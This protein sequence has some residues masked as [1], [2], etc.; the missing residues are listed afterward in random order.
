MTFG[1]VAC[2]KLGL[3]SQTCHLFVYAMGHFLKYL[4]DSYEACLQRCVKMGSE[5]ILY[6]NLNYSHVCEGHIPIYM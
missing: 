5:L 6:G 3:V 2:S 4:A 1:I